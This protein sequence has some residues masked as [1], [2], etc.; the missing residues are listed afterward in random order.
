[1]S[2][3]AEQTTDKGAD[4]GVQTAAAAGADAGA[5]VVAGQAAESA[6]TEATVATGAALVRPEGLADEFWDD[7]TGVKVADLVVA[8]REKTEAEAA[9]LADV[10]QGD[11]TYDF[12]LSD[13]VTV[14]EGFAVEID[15]KDPFLA[16]AAETLK[17]A[18]TPKAEFQ[19]LLD[20]Y[21]KLQ[22][23]A[24]EAIVADLAAQMDALG[25]NKAVRVQAIEDFVGANL[26]KADAAALTTALKTAPMLAPALEQLVALAKRSPQAATATESAPEAKQSVVDRWFPNSMKNKAA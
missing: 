22:I 17:A 12:A 6:S 4:E 2:E 26:K 18:G 11:A 3:T 21:A 24:Q 1:M 15:A 20:G 16:L 14:P 25:E 23:E 8:L 10:P 7:A 13:A 5:E 19:K 9:R